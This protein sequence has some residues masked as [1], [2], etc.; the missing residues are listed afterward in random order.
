MALSLALPGAG[1]HVLKERRQW[2]Y[3]ALEVAGWASYLN[4]RHAAID[5][6]RRYR[7]FA[8]ENGRIQNGERVDGPFAYY[9]ALSKWTQSGAFDSDG[10]APGVQPE[11]DPATYNGSVWNLATRI[12][13]P[14][15]MPVPETDPAYRS[16]LAYY[17]ENAFGT[18]LLWDWSGTPETQNEFAGLI[19]QSDHRFSQATT[20]LGVVIANHLISAADAYLSARGGAGGTRLRIVP[21]ERTTGPAWWAVLSV[22]WSG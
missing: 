11:T 2:A 14:G 7:D 3:L 15:G 1:Q 20:V 8:W 9:E 19:H 17:Q 21:S 4:R 6:R 10:G 18:A 22:P 12:F 5:L 16:A 13:F